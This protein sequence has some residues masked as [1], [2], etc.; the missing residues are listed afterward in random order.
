MM[1]VGWKKICISQYVNRPIICTYNSYLS[2]FIAI[3]NFFAIISF[4]P[5]ISSVFFSFITT[6]GFHLRLFFMAYT[7]CVSFTK[8]NCHNFSSFFAP[9]IIAFDFFFSFVYFHSYIFDSILLFFFFCSKPVKNLH[10]MPRLYALW[11]YDSK[12]VS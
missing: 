7:L 3:I 4:S 5:K 6:I 2:I 10:C 8:K 1:S 9:Q 11:I 12:S